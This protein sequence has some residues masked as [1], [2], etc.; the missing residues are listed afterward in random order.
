MTSILVR[1]IQLLFSV[2]IL[3]VIHELGHFLLA[4]AFKVHVERFF[5]F[6][7]PWF[8]IFKKKIGKTIYGIGW[9]P[10]GG[11]VKISGMITE[12]D[13]STSTEKK[14]TKDWEFRSKSS[15]KRL[16]IVLGGIIS[17]VLL[18]I[19]IFSFLL[20][21]Y[22]DIFLPT[23]NVKYGIE[24]DSLGKKI[25]LKNGDK[26]LFVNGKFIPYFNDI[27]KAV[28]LG[29]S[30]TIDRMGKIIHLSLNDD[31]KRYFFDRKEFR[32]FIKPRVPPIINYV[33]K[34]SGAY[35]SGLKNNDE[36]LAINSEFILFSDQLKDILSKYK[37]QTILISIN[38]N[39]KLFQKEVFLNQKGILGIYLKDFI[40]MDQIFSFEKKNYSIIESFPYGLKKSWDVL[41]N[42]IFFFKNVFHLE[43]RAY[44]HIGSFFSMAK[45]FPDQWNWGL[46][47][48]L[49]ATLSIWLA[50][51]N[52]FPIPSLDGGY[53]LFIMI[54]MITKKRINERIFERFTIIGFLTISLIMFMV[55]IWD[56]FKVF[57]S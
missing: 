54:E 48:T 49:T 28:I 47:W 40:D 52:L 39:G 23:K 3:I 43:T 14:S 26:I 11:Y 56:I 21:K 6:F 53:I 55:I 42:Q 27:P 38:R 30:I 35:K 5:L 7:D 4:K 29:N 57:F 19:I 41:K 10:L 32:F 16:L 12:E 15:V 25:G 2:S 33:I 24:V 34:N 50:F 45:E 22:G 37:N 1:S 46:F 17:N 44:K 51:L 9:I 13:K 8:S 31:K 20:F 36:I 18:S